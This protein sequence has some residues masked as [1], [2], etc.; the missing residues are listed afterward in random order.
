MTS[1]KGETAVVVMMQ[2]QKLNLPALR[3]NYSFVFGFFASALYLN[4]FCDFCPVSL[5]TDR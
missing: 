4:Y 2:V 1:I 3:R 5:I